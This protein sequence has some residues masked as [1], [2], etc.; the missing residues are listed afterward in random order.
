MS[1]RQA[2]W[3]VVLAVG[4]RRPSFPHSI[5]VLADQVIE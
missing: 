5:L 3:L 1:L 2:R 4:R